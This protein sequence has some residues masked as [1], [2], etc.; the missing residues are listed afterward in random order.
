MNSLEAT[1]I[2]AP[3]GKTDDCAKFTIEDA[4]VIFTFQDICMVGQDY[5]FGC[6]VKSD[7]TNS[8]AIGDTSYPASPAW[9]RVV[10]KFNAKSVDFAIK[11]VTPGTYYLY[12]SKLEIGTVDT[13]WT[14]AP[15][16][17]F[18][19]SASIEV[20]LD[21]ITQTVTDLEG[22][23]SKVEQTAESL[24]QTITDVE[25][26]V[27]Q[28]QQTVD[29]VQQ[30]VGDLEG[31]Y[32]SLQ[33]TVNGISSTVSDVEGNVSS[34]T[35]TVD[36]ISST[37]GDLE[38][39]YSQLTQTVN[40]FEVSINNANSTANSA[41]STAQQN[42]QILID[43]TQQY[44]T[45]PVGY[46]LATANKTINDTGNSGYI[47]VWGWIGGWGANNGGQ[48]DVMIP[49]RGTTA[50]GIVISQLDDHAA[51]STM[52]SGEGASLRVRNV[53]NKATLY[54]A[55]TG[56]FS[57][58]LFCEGKDFTINN[59][60]NANWDTGT[61]IWQSHGARSQDSKTATNYL[62]F[63]SSGLCVGNMTG[64]LG[65]NALITSS[66]YQIRNGSTVLSS[67][68]ATTIRLGQN[69]SAATTYFAGNHGYISYSSNTFQI[70]SDGAAQL[71]SGSN[72]T[73][74]GGAY[75][76]TLLGGS[77]SGSVTT[78]QGNTVIC[79]ETGTGNKNYTPIYR[80]NNPYQSNAK[81]WTANVNE[82]NSLINAGWKSE[83]TGWY[84]FA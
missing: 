28:L 15:E 22:N 63:D 75:A 57:I 77:S 20:T 33:Q 50:S 72:L 40:G 55:G 53:N 25:G 37:V 27:S 16:D 4:N 66:Q 68:G 36:G 61:A 44:V 48:I 78:I 9:N 5:V 62:R 1:E 21:G 43:K 34:L 12:N 67:F 52:E 11:F 58:R 6:Y 84:A 8:I 7:D 79:S 69:S 60:T 35:Q 71:T 80:L 42:G 47:H 74:R 23:V 39:N 49:L 76:T 26:N 18:E 19:K 17:I 54:A 83:G 64:T 24:T 45:S 38:G 2:V 10:N 3:N 82:R 31:N 46:L 59:A 30:T 70:H 13:D 29:G 14:P 81:I 41:L 73:V 51:A 32:S 65:Y 56:Y